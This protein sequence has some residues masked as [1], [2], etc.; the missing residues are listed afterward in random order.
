MLPY[1]LHTKNTHQ[2]WTVPPAP[3]SPHHCY[4]HHSPLGDTASTSAPLPC[5]VRS[6]RE[7]VRQPWEICIDSME[8]SIRVAEGVASWEVCIDSS[9]RVGE[10]REEEGGFMGGMH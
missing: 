10:G 9:T 1:P 3:P 7:K 2:V 4:T 5:P 8:H 6:E